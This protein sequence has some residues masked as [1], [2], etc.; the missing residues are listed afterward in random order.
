MHQYI[1]T[2]QTHKNYK[3]C[4][5]IHIQNS[6]FVQWTWIFT[7]NS[8]SSSYMYMYMYAKI[9]YV[10]DAQTR[11]HAYAQDKYSAQCFWTCT[12][13][14]FHAL[15]PCTDMCIRACVWVFLYACTDTALTQAFHEANPNINYQ[16]SRSAERQHTIMFVH[17]PH[18]HHH[19]FLYFY[20]WAL[21]HSHDIYTLVTQNPGN[22]AP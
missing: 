6:S 10:H 4:T 21:P 1:N 9:T 3:W 12:V 22:E 20:I 17:H 16:S 13:Y 8:C 5:C 7:F 18:H 19:A 15:T 11:T 14:E 2:P